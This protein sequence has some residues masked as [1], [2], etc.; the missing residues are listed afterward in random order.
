MKRKYTSEQVKQSLEQIKTFVPGA[1]IGMD[2]IVGFPN[3]TRAHFEETYLNLVTSPWSK[4]HVFPYS[5]RQGTR[6][7]LMAE[8]V[9]VRE[10]KQRALRLRELSDER[11]ASVSRLQLHS[12]KKVLILNKPARGA[13]GLSRDYFSVDFADSQHSALAGTEVS[14]QIIAVQNRPGR[15][16]L[17]I[18]KNQGAIA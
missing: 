2:V 13:I 3:E 11:L 18:A 8:K 1:F 9:E 7:A 4:I 16:P 17:L 10:R 15:E 5:E 6:A 12:F 14:A